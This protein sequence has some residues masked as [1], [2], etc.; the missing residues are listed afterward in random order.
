MKY[1]SC[2][3]KRAGVQ[4]YLK[5]SRDHLNYEQK[6]QITHHK[7]RELLMYCNT[8]KSDFVCYNV[9]KIQE[10]LNVYQTRVSNWSVSF[11]KL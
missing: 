10:N 7:L 11:Y 3:K 8:S 6:L 4:L 5:T 1:F 9:N 2:K